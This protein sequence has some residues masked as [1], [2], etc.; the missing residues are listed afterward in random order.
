M[1]IRPT[2]L[3]CCVLLLVDSEV[4]LSTWLD[5]VHHACDQSTMHLSARRHDEKGIWRAPHR[6]LL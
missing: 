2:H 5:M 6:V 1:I 4:A 3:P